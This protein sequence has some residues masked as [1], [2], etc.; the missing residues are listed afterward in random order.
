M[1]WMY[2]L[3]HQDSR[4]REGAV[5]VTSMQGILLNGLIAL[6]KIMTGSLSGSVA[7]LA[8]GVNNAT[9]A[10]T[11]V[12]ALVGTRLSGRRPTAKHPFGFGRME[13]LTGL[14]ISVLILVSGSEM[15]LGSVRSIL[16]PEELKISKAALI[17][18]AVSAV[19]KFFHG[20]STIRVGKKVDSAA[21]VAVGTESRN[22]SFVSAVTVFSSLLW[23][24]FAVCVDGWAGVINSVIILKAGME[25][26][27]DTVSSLLGES[28]NRELADT[29]YQEI[30]GCEIVQNAADMRLHDYGPDRFSGSVNIEVD[31]SKT[32][33][34]VYEVIHG[35][36]LYLMHTYHVTMVFGIYAVN[37]ASEAGRALRQLLAEFVRV[38]PHVISYHAVFVSEAEMKIYCDLVVDYKLQDWEGV[39][40]QLV[41]QLQRQYPGYS[42]EI[43]VETE[44]V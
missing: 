37:R 43:V 41:E 8:E 38:Q 7:I 36:Q 22:D 39:R 25:V 26:L 19:I 3:L 10:A 35:L 33:E 17:L 40:G 24:L 15:L 32:V 28:G 21:L 34:E 16:H 6:A 31:H 23:V 4:T 11:S 5:T 12:L 27:L 29:L 2:R 1:G 18:I 13:Y 14:V 20:Q 44:Y 30:R 42:T 9:D